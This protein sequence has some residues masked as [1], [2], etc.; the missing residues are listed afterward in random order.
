MS[1]LVSLWL[2]ISQFIDDAADALT[3]DDLE[4]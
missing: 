1:W 4:D 3:R 2:R